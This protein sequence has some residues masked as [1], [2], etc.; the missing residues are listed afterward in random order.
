MSKRCENCGERFDSG[1]V[2]FCSVFC[3][4]DY[5]FR[6]EVEERYP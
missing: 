6:V 1:R 4:R 2:S 5:M 3:Q